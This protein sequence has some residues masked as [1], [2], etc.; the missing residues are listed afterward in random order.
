MP[1]ITCPS[2]LSGVIRKLKVKEENILSDTRQARN[3]SGLNKVLASIWEETTAVGPYP[4]PD[5]GR[6]NW[7]RVLVGD[8]FYA[9]MQMRIATYGKDFAFR[10]Q[11]VNPLCKQQFEWEVPLDKLELKK[12]SEESER[13]YKD[14]NRFETTLNG[15]RVHFKLL[16]ADVQ[17]AHTR[18]RAEKRDQLATESMLLQIIEVEGVEKKQLRS[19]IENLDSDQAQELREE[20]DRAGCGIE[21]TIDVECPHCDF[22]FD[23][24]LPVGSQN[25][26]SRSKKRSQVQEDISES[27]QMQSSVRS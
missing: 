17:K 24:E 7:S 3:G 25:F 23:T 10:Q 26:F 4:I 13:I 2:G 27:S 8:H 18:I 9:V 6:P 12:L 20:F 16:T 1:E 21:T 19:W 15:T 22:Q 14:G 5:G 11:C